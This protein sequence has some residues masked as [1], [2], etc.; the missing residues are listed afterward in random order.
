MCRY[1]IS[2]SIRLLLVFANLYHYGSSE[3][4]L[5]TVLIQFI[6]WTFAWQ[7]VI[8]QSWYFHISFLGHHRNKP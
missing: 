1:V 5:I 7:C 2:L 3:Q 6:P 8:A 4:V